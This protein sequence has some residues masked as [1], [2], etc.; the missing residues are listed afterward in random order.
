MVSA[1]LIVS[2]NIGQRLTTEIEVVVYR[3][4]D[5]KPEEQYR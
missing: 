4:N 3:V 5:P 1:R 2:M